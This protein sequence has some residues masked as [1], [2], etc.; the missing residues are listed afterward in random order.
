M[1]K[2]RNSGLA[3]VKESPDQEILIVVIQRGEDQGRER[4]VASFV[5][6]AMA[7]KKLAPG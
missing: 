2:H 4:R 3:A 6:Y 7:Q 5:Q 1:E